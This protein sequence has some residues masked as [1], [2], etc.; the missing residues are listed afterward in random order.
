MAA[1][2]N[3]ESL[4]RAG[5]SWA[6]FSMKAADRLNVGAEIEM[7]QVFGQIVGTPCSSSPQSMLDG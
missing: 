5:K 6:K 3:L 4:T 1:R 2:T 7:P